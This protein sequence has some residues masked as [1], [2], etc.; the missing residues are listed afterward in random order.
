MHKR[1]QFLV[2]P[3]N[4]KLGDGYKVRHSRRQAW[5]TALKMGEGSH[6]DV[7]VQTHP[8]RRAHWIASDHRLL[9]VIERVA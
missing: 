2:Y 8:R 1:K 3:P 7:S 9:W 6:V 5:K 4:Y